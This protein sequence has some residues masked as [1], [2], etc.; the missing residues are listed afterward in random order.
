M[1]LTYSQACENNK[2]AILEVLQRVFLQ[3]KQVLEI[4]S[5]TGQH[6]LYFSANLP[7][8]TW[9]PSDL[10]INHPSII[11]RQENEGSANLL[12]P[13]LLDLN[14]PWQASASLTKKV[15]GIFTANTLH[16]VSWVLVEK[17]FV[18]VAE[19][20]S[21]GGT[22]CIYGPFNYHGQYTSQSNADFDLWLKDRDS[23]SAIRDFEKITELASSVGLSL[24]EDNTMP[25]N[26]RL[27]VFKLQ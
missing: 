5:G 8:L 27:L 6:A 22:L 25:A 4:G 14:E 19:N 17:F 21:A 23:N 13:L 11:Y 10:L 1:E 7:Q 15:D 18:G 26:N 2:T 9:Q 12:P 3:S 16:I 20:L 24:I